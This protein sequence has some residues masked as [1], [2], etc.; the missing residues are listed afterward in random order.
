MKVLIIHTRQLCYYSGDFFLDRI[1][2]AMEEAGVIVEKFSLCEN[3]DY[4]RLEQYQPHEFDA[5]LDINSK[6]PYL[7]MDTGAFWLDWLDAPFFNIIVDHPLYHHPGLIFPLK[8]Y[9]VIAIDQAHA[10]YMRE[11]YPHLKKVILM[12]LAG[13]KALTEIPFEKRKK[14]LLFTGTY[15]AKDISEEEIMNC[16]PNI[17][18]M[19]LYLRN[20][21]N[22]MEEPLEDI[23]RR[24]VWKDMT[25]TK[26]MSFQEL[27]NALY[28]L[29]RYIR[30]QMRYQIISDVAAAHIPLVI[31]GEGWI[32][33]PLG[34]DPYVTI[35][36]PQPLPLSI[37]QM[38][39]YQRILD[40]C[41]GFYCGMHDRVTSAMANGCVCYTNMSR[42]FS[43]QLENGKNLYYYSNGQELV[44]LLKQSQTD[45]FRVAEAGFLLYQQQYSWKEYA[46]KL[47]REIKLAQQDV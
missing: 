43:A 7:Q 1:Q 2:E 21:W 34:D 45:L 28:P 23:V 35:L 18:D 39:S 6:L 13:T 29:D 17:R 25:E 16:A 47:L 14:E 41:P 30:N 42:E 24:T 11:Y 4:A 5:V 38:A 31:Q 22:P 44:E 19:M 9:Y 33:S 36:P 32:Q 12:P 10:T 27:M 26:K 46:L 40:V 20:C 37:E 8:K 3:D 15:M